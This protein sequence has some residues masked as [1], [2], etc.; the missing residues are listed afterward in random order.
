MENTHTKTTLRRAKADF[1]KSGPRMPERELKKIERA[2]ELDSR[3]EELR[4]KEKR[5]KQAKR[6][7]EEKDHKER[8]AKRR[9]GIGLATQLAGFSHTQKRMKRGMES[10]LA[11]GK[12][13]E[14]VD[15]KAVGTS[16]LD[17]ETSAPLDES[18]E[19]RR[20]SEAHKQQL[21]EAQ[22][23]D[24]DDEELLAHL[25]PAHEEAKA[26]SPYT[27]KRSPKQDSS[28]EL[29]ANKTPVLITNTLRGVH[30]T[31]APKPIAYPSL[32][33][34]S[35]SLSW[36]DFLASN[37]Q[38]TRELSQPTTQAEVS[39]DLAISSDDLLDL[40]ESAGTLCPEPCAVNGVVARDFAYFKRDQHGEIILAPPKD[41]T[42]APYTSSKRV[43][44]SK[45]KSF[46]TSSPKITASGFQPSIAERSFTSRFDDFG[47]STQIL[48]DAV[49]D[50][51]SDTEEEDF[52]SLIPSVAVDRDRELMPPPPPRTS[53]HIFKPPSPIQSLKRSNF[54]AFG[55]STQILQDVADLSDGETV[56]G[57][58]SS[59]GVEDLDGAFWDEAVS[60][61]A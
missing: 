42:D 35:P 50:T 46:L 8:E 31:P 54:Q 59:F 57:A 20:Q 19:T 34:T 51:D 27:P 25:K 26:Q 55:L 60:H 16:K 9:M 44:I 5:R 48:Q 36:E 12:D 10:F 15:S 28:Q 39:P 4:E 29:T 58:G 30:H 21:P 61:G 11:K 23:D 2:A 14:N 47:L 33:T 43:N 24:L 38:I 6:K 56:E 49:D 40:H 37:T 45:P 22:E 32:A 3:A 18:I 41:P 13:K 7:R 53:P 1:M 52:A 17:E